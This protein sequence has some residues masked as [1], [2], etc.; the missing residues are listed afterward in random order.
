M[1]RLRAGRVACCGAVW[2]GRWPQV[3]LALRS[4]SGLGLPAACG[5]ACPTAFNRAGEK[6]GAGDSCPGLSAG[7]VPD[8]GTGSL[9]HSSHLGGKGL[10]NPFGYGG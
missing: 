7:L 5:Q 8:G 4:A 2:A 10:G 3:L 1:L 9:S 6:A